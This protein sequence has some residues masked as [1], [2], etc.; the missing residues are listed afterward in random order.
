MVCC[1]YLGKCSSEGLKCGSCANNSEAKR[2]Y[3]VPLPYPYPYWP[4]PYTWPWIWGTSGN[5][6]SVTSTY[7]C[8]SDIKQDY[9]TEG[10]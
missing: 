1:K 3:Y 4:Y 6:V 2:D 5:Q 8:N 10:S 7:S 9:Y